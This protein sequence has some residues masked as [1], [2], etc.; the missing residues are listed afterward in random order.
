MASSGPRNPY[1]FTGRRLDF[2][3]RDAQGHPLLTLYDYRAREYD[4][5]HGRFLQRDPAGYV[6]GMNLYEAF[7]SNP[8]RYVDPF[9]LEPEDLLA[10]Q[11]IGDIRNK[12][13]EELRQ[14]GWVAL[15]DTILANAN[16][17]ETQGLLAD[18]VAPSILY[19]EQQALVVA[20][21]KLGEPD[22]VVLGQRIFL[23]QGLTP[24][25]VVV[26]E[27]SVL[28]SSGAMAYHE[29]LHQRGKV[30]FERMIRIEAQAVQ[31]AAET[32]LSTLGGAAL[33]GVVAAAGGIGFGASFGDDI[34]RGGA[35]AARSVKAYDVGLFDELG[36]ARKPIGEILHRHHVVQSHPAKQIIRGYNRENAP[37]ILVPD[38]LHRRLPKISGEYSGNARSL[39]AGDIKNLRNLTDAPNTSLKK[40]I[41]MNIEMYPGAF[42]KLPPQGVVP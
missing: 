40:L 1:R 30:D 18:A 42:R 3:F 16:H 27:E 39:L 41:R 28:F 21:C 22:Y 8:L 20:F 10:V 4:A 31:F 24:E 36:Q 34:L 29:L 26:I 32:L 2:D 9:G 35:G 14:F 38:Y 33:E 7:A 5:L 15:A 11:I 19:E 17:V 13:R 23:A 12:S 25:E 37:S 6:D